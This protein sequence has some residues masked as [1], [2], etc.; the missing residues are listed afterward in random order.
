MVVNSLGHHSK[1]KNQR[2]TRQAKQGSMDCSTYLVSFPSKKS[3]FF[4]VLV[5]FSG[6]T[7]QKKIKVP[8]RK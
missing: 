8:L 2:I 4:L 3:L 6:K 5:I 7:N 1:A